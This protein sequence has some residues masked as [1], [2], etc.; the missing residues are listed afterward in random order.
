MEIDRQTV[1]GQLVSGAGM[2]E[3]QKPEEKLKASRET[4]CP[5]AMRTCAVGGLQST[6]KGQWVRGV[7]VAAGIW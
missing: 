3:V 6:E 5:R 7:E 1:P 2:N 4:A